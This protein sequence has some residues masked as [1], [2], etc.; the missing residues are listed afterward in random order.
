MAE[1]TPTFEGWA[2]LELMG[3][4]RLGGYLREQDVAGAAFIRIDVPEHSWQEGCTCGST[5]PDSTA[6]D[7][8]TSACAMFREETDTRPLDVHATQ[9]Y[10]PAAV[11]C[12]TPVTEKMAR[13]IAQTARPQPVQRWELEPAR[14]PVPD[15][16][17]DEE[18]LF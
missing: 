4:R 13:A 1:E 9:F 17:D 3:H 12:I 14:A 10:A 15:D 2:I 16:R 8:H 18:E 6:P 11:Y 5:D 7:D